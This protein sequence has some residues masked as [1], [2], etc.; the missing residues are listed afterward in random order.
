MKKYRASISLF[1]FILVVFSLFFYQSSILAKQYPH[2]S[3]ETLEGDASLI[4]S[5][6]IEGELSNDQGFYELFEL[7]REGTKYQRE[8][9]FVERMTDVYIPKEIAQLEKEVP[10]FMRGKG[11]FPEHYMKKDDTLIFVDFPY[12]NLGLFKGYIQIECYDFK[13]KESKS[14]ELDFPIR[15]DYLSLEKMYLE[16][17]RLYLFIVVTHFIDELEVEDEVVLLAFD[18]E[19][20]EE[21]Y[22]TKEK[23][24]LTD[25]GSQGLFILGDGE[26]G[27]DFLL[28]Q[29]EIEEIIEE[30][31]EEKVKQ[32][33]LKSADLSNG[34]WTELT[35]PEQFSKGVYPIAYDGKKV[36][37]IDSDPQGLSFIRYDIESEKREEVFRLEENVLPVDHFMLYWSIENDGKWY[38]LQSDYSNK[39]GILMIV[40]IAK[41]ELL[42]HGVIEAEEDIE[43]FNLE[44]HY[45]NLMNRLSL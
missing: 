7:T 17:D 6:V 8:K 38:L 12:N 1:L 35:L 31:Y 34:S 19:K 14:F 5:L 18:L 24:N 44:L 25:H 4:D 29:L 36:T 2:Y 9:S 33:V 3:F 11:T 37:F 42:Y 45:L 22:M 15:S 16:D 43:K 10:H 28:A 32:V 13:T 23:F 41:T 26:S 21:I 30:D 27:S 39:R 20:G 40:D